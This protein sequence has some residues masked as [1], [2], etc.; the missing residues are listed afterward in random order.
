MGNEI[1]VPP[2]PPLPLCPIQF[3]N[4]EIPK[5]NREYVEVAVGNIDQ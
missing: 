5:I 1:G 2:P 3:W 4:R